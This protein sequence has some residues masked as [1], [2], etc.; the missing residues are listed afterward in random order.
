MNRLLKLAPHLV[1]RSLFRKSAVQLL[2]RAAWDRIRNDTLAAANHKCAVC[3]EPGDDCHELWQYD[4]KNGIALLV[5]F[6]TIA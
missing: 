4:E 2:P 1:P 3:K 6:R 5:E